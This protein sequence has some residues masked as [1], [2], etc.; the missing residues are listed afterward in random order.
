MGIKL[1]M[2][3]W[4]SFR[5]VHEGRAAYE[6]YV[7]QMGKAADIEA[8]KK[9]EKDAEDEETSEQAHKLIFDTLKKLTKAKSVEDFIATNLGT[10]KD[11]EDKQAPIFLDAVESVGGIDKAIEHIQSRELE[12]ADKALPKLKELHTKLSSGNEAATVE[13][14]DA[15]EYT[16]AKGKQTSVVVVE[17]EHPKSGEVI[18]RQIDPESCKQKGSNFAA[19]SPEVFAQKAGEPIEQCAAGSGGESQIAKLIS[20]KLEDTGLDDY[21]KKITKRQDLYELEK[22]I[23]NLALDSSSPIKS[24]DLLKVVIQ[25]KKD[26]EGKMKAAKGV[27]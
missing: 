6:D 1:I 17:P 8:G 21:I 12:G 9:A 15:V 7:N 19:G 4:R 26:I 13:K 16:T 23:L 22:V 2:E 27:K 18:A 14:G 25:L 3:N 11:L 20:Q 24:D 5:S 10:G